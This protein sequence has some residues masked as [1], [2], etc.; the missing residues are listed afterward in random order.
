[1]D[2]AIKLAMKED[3]ARIQTRLL[4][5]L[6]ARD[7]GTRCSMATVIM[8]FGFFRF[9]KKMI[10]GG[11]GTKTRDRGD[12]S[13]VR[14]LVVIWGFSQSGFFGLHGGAIKV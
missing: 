2:G 3:C 13:F 9:A 5:S 14:V 12:A 10:H 8:R 11:R 6:Q 1:M 4:F 7:D